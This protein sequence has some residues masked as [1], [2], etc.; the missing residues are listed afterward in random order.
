MGVFLSTLNQIAF[1]FT[2]IAAGYIL[3]KLGILPEGAAKVLAKLE[4][5]IF[6]PALVLGTFIENFTVERLASAWKL[7]VVS[8]AIAIVMIPVSILVSKA[9]TRDKYIQNIYTYGLAFSNFGFMGNAVVSAM[10]PDIFFEYLLFTL[11]LWVEIYVW[12]VPILLMGDTEKQQTLKDRVKPF[13]NPMFISMLIGIV[14]GLLKIP[15]PSFF[16]AVLDSSSACMSPVAMLLT[17]ITVSTIS[18]KKTFTDIRTYIISFVRLL[19]LPLAFIGISLVVPV[20]KDKTILT[21]ALCSLAMPLGLN[22]IVI[23]SAYGKDTT[24]AAGM[25]V[26]SHLMALASIPLVF[27]IAGL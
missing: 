26:I 22:T 6:I 23:P 20:F 7:L 19:A 14:I 3:A 27:A 18:F 25:A 24:V 11:P 13:I 5:T 21:C 4:N 10:F 17:G 15:M 9:V 12:G 8:T 2:L 16:V 1:L